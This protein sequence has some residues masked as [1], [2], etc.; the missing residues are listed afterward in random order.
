MLCPWFPTLLNFH[1]IIFNSILRIKGTWPWL[2]QTKEIKSRGMSSSFGGGGGS[3]SI[4][5]YCTIQDCPR[6]PSTSETTMKCGMSYKS[7]TR[8]LTSSLVKNP[9]TKNIVIGCALS[10][11]VHLKPLLDRIS[12]AVQDLNRC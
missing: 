7:V 2:T 5:S 11:A 12:I 3:S 4:T 10:E 8:A 9:T 1:I 6:K